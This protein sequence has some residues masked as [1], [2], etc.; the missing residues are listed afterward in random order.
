MKKTF[1]T[2]MTLDELAKNIEKAKE[3]EIFPIKIVGKNKIRV[4][5]GRA[6]TYWAIDMEKDGEITVERR[7]TIWDWI[8]I[9]TIVAI[10][11]VIAYLV[12]YDGATINDILFITGFLLCEGLPLYYLCTI[13]PM[14]KIKKFICKFEGGYKD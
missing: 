11:L 12:F 7:I 2:S 9:L 6:T 1:L 14:E 13:F 4:S 10:D 5:N 3:N 8:T